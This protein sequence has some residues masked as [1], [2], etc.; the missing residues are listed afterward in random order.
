VS[1]ASWGTKRSCPKCASRFYDLDKH[2]AQCPKCHHSFDPAAMLK[3]R[4]G[5]A[6]KF[7]NLTSETEG[8][9]ALLNSIIAKASATKSAAKKSKADDDLDDMKSDGL[10]EDVE[11]MEDFE[12]IEELDVADENDGDDASEETIMEDFAV[13]GEA[14]VD[15][16]DEDDDDEDDAGDGDDEPAPSKSRRSRR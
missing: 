7:S 8:D 5:R 4:R 16:V 14:I 13:Q 11:E 10:V 15:G 2:P 3:P 1:N 9:D 6:R 12:S